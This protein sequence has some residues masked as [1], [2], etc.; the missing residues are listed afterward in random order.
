MKLYIFIFNIIIQLTEHYFKSII[1]DTKK[2]VIK[3][4][5]EK[6]TIMVTNNLALIL[7]LLI[8]TQSDCTKYKLFI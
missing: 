1:I 8:Y 4:I 5:D 3:G 2:M 7:K 6:I